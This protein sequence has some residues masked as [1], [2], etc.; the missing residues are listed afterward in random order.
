MDENGSEIRGKVPL[1]QCI[2]HMCESALCECV[3]FAR[4]QGQEARVL[5]IGPRVETSSKWAGQWAGVSVLPEVARNLRT[6][7]YTALIFL[8][9]SA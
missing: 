6:S 1:I 9:D 7:S 8:A 4:L 3:A 2:A 5:T